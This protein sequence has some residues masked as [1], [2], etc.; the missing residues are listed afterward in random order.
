MVVVVIVVVVH[1]M[2]YHIHTLTFAVE[3]FGQFIKMVKFG[4]SILTWASY[5][6]CL[7][8]KVVVCLVA[9]KH[10]YRIGK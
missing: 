5:G 3:L 7:C 6:V 10:V 8:P 2:I 4:K 1:G 9:S